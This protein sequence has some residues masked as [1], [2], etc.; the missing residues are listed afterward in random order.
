MS[1]WKAAVLWSGGLLL[2]GW[3]AGVQ[4]QTCQANADCPKG[5][6]CEVTGGSTCA[7]PACAPGEKCPPPPPCE[8]MVYRSCQPGPCA[9][10]SDCAEGM[11]CYEQKIQAC[12]GGAAL[13]CLPGSACPEPAPP[14]CTEQSTRSCVP[15]YLLPCT[16]DASCGPGFTCKEELS[17]GCAGS[18]AAGAPTPQSNPASPAPAPDAGSS[19]SG[20]A[21]QRPVPVI[22]GGQA[23]PPNEPPLPA[24]D[25]G[26]ALDGGSAQTPPPPDTAC[27]CA[28][29]GQKRCELNEI[30]CKQDSDCPAHFTCQNIAVGDDT[31]IAACD[32]APGADA[33]ACG[34]APPLTPV[35]PVLRCMPPYADAVHDLGFGKAESASGSSTAQPVANG[36]PPGPSGGSTSATPPP[37]AAGDQAPASAAHAKACSVALPG[38]SS[39]S[40]EATWLIASC[41]A[42]ALSRLRRRRG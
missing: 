41:A 3:A 37:A 34:A 12:S 36:T 38:A 21:A 42:L 13:P 27:S 11:V 40:R 33:G 15:R 8:N 20:F 39:T 18:A 23:P 24:A 16:D 6:T 2:T 25:A 4:A 17:C 32:P 10:D 28:P 35:Q 9:T 26:V 14:V 19:G 1:V 31:P 30:T 22:D 5:F 29:S 7:S